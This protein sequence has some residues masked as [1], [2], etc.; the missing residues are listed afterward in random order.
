MAPLTGF[1]SHNIRLPGGEQ[2]APGH[3]MVADSGVCR[4]A[5]RYLDTGFDRPRRD[6][7]VADLGCLEGGYAAEFARAGYDVTGFEAREENYDRACLLP[8]ALELPDLRF[9]LGDVRDVLPGRRFDAVFCCGLLYHLDQPAAFLR[10]LGQ[11]TGRLLILNTHFSQP[12]GHGEDLHGPGEACDPFLSVNEGR[13]GH[14][15]REGDNRWASLGE[16]T[17]FWLAKPD[18]IAALGDAGFSEV[19]EHDDWRYPE[20][21]AMP[22]GSGGATADRGMFTAVRW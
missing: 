15:F 11:V 10:L 7:T 1:T 22:W 5:L 20:H 4:E 8:A 2:T 16:K 19:T 17:S 21:L 13:T 3:V 18:L 14:W 6:V 9:I 12:G